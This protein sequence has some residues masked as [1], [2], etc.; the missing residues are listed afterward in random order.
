MGVARLYGGDKRIFN[1]GEQLPHPIF[2]QFCFLHLESVHRESLAC[3]LLDKGTF[4]KQKFSLKSAQWLHEHTLWL[5]IGGMGGGYKQVAYSV[6]NMIA[7]LAG[8][9]CDGAKPACALKVTSGVSTAV[10]SAMLAIQNRHAT[11]AEG[12]IEDD[13]DA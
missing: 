11:N 5:A 4:V 9:V 10:L 6:K 1:V 8:M 7:N 2:P 13:V 12:L 3:L